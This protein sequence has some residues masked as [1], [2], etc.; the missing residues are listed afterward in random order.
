MDGH[1]SLSFQFFDKR[2]NAAFKVF[3]NFG[4]KDP[5]PELIQTYQKLIEKFKKLQ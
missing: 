1:E 2:G 4:G 3:L 5:G